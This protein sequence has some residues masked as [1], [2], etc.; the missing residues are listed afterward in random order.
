VVPPGAVRDNARHSIPEESAVFTAIALIKAERTK[1]NDVASQ[2]AELPGISEV[3]S[4][5]GRFDLVA[6]IRVADSEQ[7][8]DVVTRHMLKIDGILDTETMPAFKTLSRHDL[9]TM[10]SIGM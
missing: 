2:L 5:G 9:E 4:V 10:F 6:I 1:V 7:M 3:Y 8:A